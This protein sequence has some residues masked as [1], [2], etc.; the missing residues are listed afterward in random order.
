MMI[1]RW[2]RRHL[3][4]ERDTEQ[5]TGAVT[6]AVWRPAVQF[7]AAVRPIAWWRAL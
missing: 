4:R 5:M 1:P 2:V 7:D 3:R 6:D